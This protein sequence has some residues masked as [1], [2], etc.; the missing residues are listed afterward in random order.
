MGL[1]GIGCAVSIFVKEALLNK[2]L[3]VQIQQLSLSLSLEVLLLRSRTYSCYV[4]TYLRLSFLYGS[5][6]CE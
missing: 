2:E 4:L 5:P 1:D 3:S 6:F